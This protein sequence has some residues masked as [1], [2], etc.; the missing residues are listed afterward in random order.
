MSAAVTVTP[1]LVF[2]GSMDGGLRAYDTETG[3]ILW[4]W[5]ANRS[6]ETVNGVEA[7]GGS[8]DGP[9]PVIVNGMLYVS[10]GNGGPFGMPGNVLL[11]F[12]LE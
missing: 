4:T 3:E 6:F 9:G 8:L 11:A 1:G 10:A 7:R 2:A 12:S 5:N